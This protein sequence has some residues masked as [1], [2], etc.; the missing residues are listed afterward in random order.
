MNQYE[1][2]H[3]GVRGMKWG[4][5]KKYKPHPIKKSHKRVELDI[6]NL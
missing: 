1:L 6:T 2:Y 5:R 3:H 4:I